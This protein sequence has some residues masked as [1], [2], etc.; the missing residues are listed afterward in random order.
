MRFKPNGFVVGALLLFAESA[1]AAGL[2]RAASVVNSITSDVRTL[3]PLVAVVALIVLAVMW[4]LRVIRFATLCQ[5]G[6]GIVLAGSAA[7]VVSMLFS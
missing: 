4:G 2:T 5:F 1:H 6:A 7:E 3:I